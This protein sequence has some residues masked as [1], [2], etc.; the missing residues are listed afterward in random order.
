MATVQTLRDLTALA[1][2]DAR[3][4]TLQAGVNVADAINLA[5]QQAKEA[6]ALEHAAL[7]QAVAQGETKLSAIG[8]E[9][10]QVDSQTFALRQKHGRLRG[11]VEMNAAEREGEELRRLARDLGTDRER[12]QEG[13]DAARTRLSVLDE[14]LA[15]TAGAAEG[16]EPVAAAA[17]QSH[18]L[19]ELRSAREQ[20][21]KSLPVVLFKRYEMVRARKGTSGL[22]TTTGGICSGCHVSLSPATFSK[23]RQEPIVEV[24][25]SCHRLVYYASHLAVPVGAAS[26][27]VPASHGAG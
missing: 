20:L 22:A 16:A 14:I 23:M 6:R 21:A 12:T 7:T 9:L 26:P 19:L 4:T 13:I 5:A 27:S 3:I 17:D 2:L 15:G 1:D 24:C 11:E 25:P 18:A 8:K 10:R